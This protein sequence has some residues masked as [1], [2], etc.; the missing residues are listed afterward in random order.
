VLSLVTGLAVLALPVTK[1]EPFWR[2]AVLWLGLWLGLLSVQEFSGY[3]ITGPFA[4]IGDIGS[5]L[6][7]TDAPAVLGWLGFVLGWVL[8]YLLGRYAVRRLVAF[9]DPRKPLAPQLRA[10]GLSRGCSVPPPWPPHGPASLRCWASRLRVSSPLLRESASDQV[11]GRHRGARHQRV[12]RRRNNSAAAAQDAARTRRHQVT[13]SGALSPLGVPISRPRSVSMTGVT[14]WLSA[15]PRRTAGIVEV[16]TN[17][18]D[19]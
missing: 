8:T 13:A 5:V 11:L 7:V 16:G 19:R 3:L 1:L 2:L 14:G 6:A 4:D 17:A 9:T 10:L 18:L 15:K 12:V